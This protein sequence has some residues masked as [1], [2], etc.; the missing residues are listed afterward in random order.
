MISAPARTVQ[1]QRTRRPIHRRRRPIVVSDAP[2]GFTVA[3]VRTT[4]A[5]SSQCPPTKRPFRSGCAP[6]EVQFASVAGRFR[7]SAGHPCDAFV[8]A[9]RNCVN[10]FC[11]TTYSHRDACVRISGAHRRVAVSESTSPLLRARS[12]HKNTKEAQRA[13]RGY[14]RSKA[15]VEPPRRGVRQGDTQAVEAS[16]ADHQITKS[17][18]AGV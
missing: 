12:N 4:I 15:R 7:S 14:L 18:N 1:S 5:P 8:R 16:S 17:P 10:C 13:R 2:G 9:V 3:A 6:V 11:T